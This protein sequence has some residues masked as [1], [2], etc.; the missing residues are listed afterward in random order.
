V[1]ITSHTEHL[2]KRSNSVA[3]RVSIK[4]KMGMKIHNFYLHLVNS[5]EI[6]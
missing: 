3:L 5:V 2:G 4:Q 6:V 1:T